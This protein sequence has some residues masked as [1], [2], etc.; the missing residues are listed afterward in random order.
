MSRKRLFQLYVWT[1]IPLGVGAC[2]LAI[3]GQPS[4]LF[5]L[6]FL[7]LAL[8]TVT[9]SRV[10]VRIPGVTASITVTDTFIF[11]TILLCGGGPATLVGAAEGLSSASRISKKARTLL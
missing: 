7:A 5:N 4:A 6:Q 3:S 10:A 9:V 11:L 8:I 2:I 1:I